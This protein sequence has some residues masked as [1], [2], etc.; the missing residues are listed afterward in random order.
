LY[1]R[2]RLCI[3]AA[4]A[5][6]LAIGGCGSDS[7]DKSA[8]PGSGGSPGNDGGSTSTGGGGSE[9]QPAPVPNDCVQDVTPGTQALTCEGLEL[10]LT[11]PDACLNEACGLIADV[12][13]FGMTGQVMEDQTHMQS[14]AGAEGYIVVQPTASGAPP[15]WSEANDPQVRAIMQ[16]VIDAWHVDPKRVHIDGYSM[17]GWMTWRFVCKYSDLIASAAP[18]AAGASRGVCD[19]S[20]ANRPARQIPIFY[21]HGRL[22][23]LV[24]YSQ[25]ETIVPQVTG[26]WYAGVTPSVI[27]E[28]DDY[29]WERWTNAEGNVFE[30]LQHDWKFAPGAVES[31]GGH[32]FPGSDGGLACPGGN[33]VVWSETVLQFFIDHPM[34]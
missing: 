24:T 28:A 26:A 10:L 5:L 1:S 13:G 20:E 8:D 2:A 4:L 31:L 23:G 17:G 11:V 15:A 6:A 14:L 33:P 9:P 27:E 25:A 7:S 34:E 3:P 12:H 29:R 22:D 19:F 21:T 18:M 16:H 32:C 30:F